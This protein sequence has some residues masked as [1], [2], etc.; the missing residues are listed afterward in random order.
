MGGACKGRKDMKR[1]YR[2]ISAEVDILEI[3]MYV[4]IGDDSIESTS[5]LETDK[6]K[7]Q[8]CECDILDACY[9]S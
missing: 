9:F 5:L 6:F 2:R 7:F 1:L 3:D 8:N 4:E